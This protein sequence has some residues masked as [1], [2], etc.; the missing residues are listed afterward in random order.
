VLILLSLSSEQIQRN[1]QLRIE[2]QGRCL[3][4]MF[5]KQCKS[6]ID[7][8]KAPASTLENPSAP[9]SDA[10]P[11]SPDKSEP[12]ASQVDHDITITDP[13]SANTRMEESSPEQKAPETKAPQNSEP[14]AC[15]A[16]SQPSKRPRKDE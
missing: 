5:E 14:D 11:D 16:N 9:S 8:L 6:G 1:L 3:Q 15:E 4:M 2:E 12:E 7:K 13:G 10:V